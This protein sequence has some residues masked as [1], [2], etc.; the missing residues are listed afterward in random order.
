MQCMFI[1]SGPTSLTAPTMM[2]LP[3]DK[4]ALTVDYPSTLI[5]TG[6]DTGLSY[7]IQF[8]DAVSITTCILSSRRRQIHRTVQCGF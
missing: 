1:P 8:N 7:T 5:D 2:H 4:G 6:P 3:S